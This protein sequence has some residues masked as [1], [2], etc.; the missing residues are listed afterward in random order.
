MLQIIQQ[1]KL[2]RSDKHFRVN[3]ATA[4]TMDASSECLQALLTSGE[5]KF[6]KASLRHT[7][8]SDFNLLLGS[9][10][11]LFFSD[12]AIQVYFC[13]HLSSL[14]M[15]TPKKK[16]LFRLCTK[17]K[18]SLFFFISITELQ[19]MALTAVVIFSTFFRSH[20]NALLKLCLSADF[21]WH[22][23]SG[24]ADLDI[25]TS[26]SYFK[27]RFGISNKK[28]FLLEVQCARKFEHPPLSKECATEGYH[29]I[30]QCFS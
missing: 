16:F 24:F 18:L 2:R 15:P 6:R 25:H 4:I 9:I 19:Y 23:S 22:L 3:S 17:N 28:I 13:M 26:K 29:F 8:Q 10:F 1:F 30:A 11:T 12:L 20:N 7:F 21:T 14:Q 5:V 27:D